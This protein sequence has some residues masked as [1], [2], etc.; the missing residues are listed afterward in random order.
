MTKNINNYT[1][2]YVTLGHPDRLADYL[3]ALIIDDVNSTDQWKGHAA[4]EVMLTSDTAVFGGEVTT[5]ID[6][7]DEYLREKTAQAFR[8]AGYI[9]R[10][11]WNADKDHPDYI[12]FED[13]LSGKYKIEN[14]MTKQSPDIAKVTKS[15]YRFND[16]GIFFGSFGKN[17]LAK[18]AKQYAQ[19][20]GDG[21]FK[22]SL[23]ENALGSDIK[24]I[25]TIDEKTKIPQVKCYSVPRLS[26]N[27][28]KHGVIA[29]TGLTGRK[30]AVNIHDDGEF[31]T[32]KLNG[33]GSMIKPFNAADL[34]LNL[35]ARDLAR[36]L[37]EG[38]F[39]GKNVTVALS[40]D[41]GDK[42]PTVDWVTVD[43]K[44]RVFAKTL[45]QQKV[46]TDEATVAFLVE[47]Y[48]LFK[49]GKFAQMVKRNFSE[50]F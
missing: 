47:K 23:T 34:L 24:V 48:S 32:A 37:S 46:D 3:A 20:S 22:R 31:R 12:T 16:K 9:P 40:C 45:A 5:S 18:K 11:G 25:T 4:V 39:H 26:S 49:P 30:T 28:R 2:E 8:E 44:C 38:F 19:S 21:L 17:S 15:G 14:H 6:L 10:E 1:T 27:F 35:Y 42:L 33:G 7:S 41:I 36:F 43:G 50:D 13:V 29:D